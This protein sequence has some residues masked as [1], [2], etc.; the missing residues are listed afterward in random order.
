M[1]IVARLVLGFGIPTC[2]VS[3]SAMIGE[4][5]YPKERPVMT[6]LFNVSYFPGQ[7][8]AAAICFGTNNIPNDWGW[9]IP[10]LLQMFPSLMQIVMIL[11]AVPSHT[12]I[13]D[14]YTDYISSF[15]P[16]SPRWL[17]T[18]DRGEEAY[19]ILVKYHAEGHAETEFIKAEI[20]QIQTTIHLELE[21]SKR[22]WLDL[23]AT[24]GM[25]RRLLV[26]SMLGLFT[27]WSGNTLI[28]YYLGDLLN[29]IGE[30]DSIFK[31]QINVSLACWNLICGAVAAG[32]VTKFRRR[33]MYLVCTIS[34]LVV[35]ISWTISMQK[36]KEALDAKQ[37]NSAAG[38]ATIF[39]IYA[40]V[41]SYALESILSRRG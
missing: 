38:I 4:L 15:I 28:S 34:S 25:R 3:G 13:Q 5:A 16:E 39:F 20:A 37:T 14:T 9:R 12:H 36:A 30:T 40:Y 10:S 17:I 8:L 21:A 41:S 1:Y 35:Y 11:S 31:Q 32:L 27:Q 19:A 18:K 33:P 22:S 2:I 6:S 29:M 24:K 23:I 26:S 7:I